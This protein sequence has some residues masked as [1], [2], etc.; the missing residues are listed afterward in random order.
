MSF[1]G[2]RRDILEDFAEHQIRHERA[3]H[4]A[5]IVA[6]RFAPGEGPRVRRL[7]SHVEAAER[8][9]VRCERAEEK[10]AA[11]RVRRLERLPL[12]GDLG[13]LGAWKHQMEAAAARA[14]A[15]AWDAA[16]L[17]RRRAS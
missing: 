8:E 12:G 1:E 5:A 7:P 17:E 9:Q 3:V 16:R 14:R 15:L 6:S 10:R 11:E 2:L 4:M 13:D